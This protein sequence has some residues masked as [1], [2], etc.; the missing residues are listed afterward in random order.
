MNTKVK[1]LLAV[2][3]I[4]VLVIAGSLFKVD[5]R[6]K[7]LVFQFGRI[8]N[9][10]VEPGLNFK[11][12]FINNVRYFDARIQTMDQEEESYLTIEKKN[13]IVD[14][15]I[16]WRVDD[17]AKFYVT[18]GGLNSNARARLAQRVNDS[19]RQEFGRRTVKDVISGDRVKIMNTVRDSVNE[20]AVEIGVEVVDVR[21]K[22]VDLDPQVSESVYSRMEA[23]RERVANDFRA[24]GA[25]TAEKIRA[26]ADKQ[27]QIIQA[28]AY[29]EAETIRGEGDA[30]AT[31]IYAKAFGQDREF[32]NLFRSLN[33]YE[34]TF[35]NK[36]DLMIIEPDSEFFKYFKQSSAGE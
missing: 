35:S 19:L 30:L 14:A 10:N 2:L 12:P 9:S 25:E 33:A 28:D 3:A 16:K 27:A 36:S 11:I 22:R 13:L 23:E 6:E 18:V 29:K 4:I 1:I 32:Y 5:Q 8:V 15:F 20:E 7:A 21:L 34:N 24:K 31:T 17:P 26:D